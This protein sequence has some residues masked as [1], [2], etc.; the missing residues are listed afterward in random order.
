MS[1]T[2]GVLR[3]AE[4]V[5]VGTEMTLGRN[6][7]TNSAFLS[8]ELSLL[9]VGVRS[10]A[11]YPDDPSIFGEGLS[12]A[13]GRADLVIVTGGLGPTRDDLTREVVARIAGGKP[14]VRDAA[15]LA[16]LRERYAALG[17]A[18]PASNDRQAERPFGSDLVHNRLGSAPGFSLRV[19]RA[20]LVSLPGVP[21][22]MTTMWEE[23][24]VP[25]L[26]RHGI[27]GGGV[28]ATRSLHLF[29][30]PES[31]VGE[32]IDDLMAITLNPYATIT[33]S[34]SVIT[35]H[36]VAKAASAEAASALLDPLDAEVTRRAGPLLFGRDGETLPE[37]LVRILRG[38]RQRVALAESCTGGRATHLLSTVP[39]VSD[40]LVAGAVAYANEAKTFLAD[41][42]PGLIREKGAV[43]AEVARAMAE[44][45]RRR[46][47]AD[48]GLAST[49]IAGPSGGTIEKPVGLVY[50]ACASPDATVLVERLHVPGDR[51]WIQERAARA[52]IDLGRRVLSG[53]PTAP[54]G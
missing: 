51:V 50:L 4:I 33:V 39:G 49:G 6:V 23:E 35:I 43:S 37:A 54:L 38:R 44:G 26:R 53:L 30:A 34:A 41:V 7:D 5:S 36:L 12:A 14:L 21:R 9:G 22:E 47:G 31:A 27:G 11:T 45:I 28:V 15:W 18:F 46:A 19:D 42:P 52:L 29:G 40:T 1:E 20:L 32:T 13:C 16:L 2:G 17:R 3:T 24:V 25:L 10:H 48:V 8:R